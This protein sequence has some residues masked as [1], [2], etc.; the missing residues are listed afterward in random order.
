MSRL[1]SYSKAIAAFVS[2][3]LTLLVAFG[4][5]LSG[6]QTA[7]ILSVVA[8]LA[9]F[10][11]PSNAPNLPTATDVGKPMQLSEEP[12]IGDPDRTPSA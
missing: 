4:V 5:D 8:T 3:V 12:R 1:A 10:L 2:S 11:A 7:A 6:E 9:V